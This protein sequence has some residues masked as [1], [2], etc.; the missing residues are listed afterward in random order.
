MKNNDKCLSSIKKSGGPI[1]YSKK[2]QTI[3]KCCGGQSCAIQRVPKTRPRNATKG[4]HF[5]ASLFEITNLMATTP[6][7]EQNAKTTLKPDTSQATI[8]SIQQQSLF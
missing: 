5:S 6:F 1:K 3:I 2:R 4:R 7:L 8:F